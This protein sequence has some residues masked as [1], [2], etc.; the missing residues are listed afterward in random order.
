MSPTLKSQG[1]V[2]VDKPS[3]KT[4]FDMVRYIRQLSQEKTVGHAGTLDPFATGLL[5]IA[6]GR[7]FTK[8]I[9]LF[10]NMSKRYEG[11]FLLGQS[12]TTLDP[13]G[14]I[15]QTQ[16]SD[17]I[18]H[19]SKEVWQKKATEFIGEYNHIPP[20]FS[21][22]KVNGKRSY[23]LARKGIKPTLDPVCV[24]IHSFDITS[25]STDMFPIISFSV[26]C[27]KGTYVRTL[28]TDLAKKVGSIGHCIDLRRVKIGEYHVNHALTIH[29]PPQD[30]NPFL[31][32]HHAPSH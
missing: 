17:K 10:Q 13:D 7:P 9:N 32:T 4:S 22:K 16:D 5:V 31:F 11:Q 27:S 26:D 2:L 15:D 3:G 6:I 12:T 8:K 19:L 23:Q 14:D 25:V 29:H 18:P 21:A 1:F 20:L 28:I 24:N 30:L